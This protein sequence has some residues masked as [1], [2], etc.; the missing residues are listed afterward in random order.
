MVS[1]ESIFER[2]V[3]AEKRIKA[4]EES[5]RKTTG[6]G[7]QLGRLARE[8]EDLKTRLIGSGPNPG[9]MKSIEEM[10]VKIGNLETAVKAAYLQV[11]EHGDVLR[12]HEGRIEGLEY[13]L[14]NAQV[15]TAHELGSNRN[16]RWGEVAL[17]GC[18][19]GLAGWLIFVV[20]LSMRFGWVAAAACFGI[21]FFAAAHILQKDNL[22]LKLEARLKIPKTVP[23]KTPTKVLPD[24]DT[25]VIDADTTPAT[26]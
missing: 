19:G 1:K 6:N 21:A 2:Q 17:W 4:L 14:N 15:E 11:A 5:L 26:G 3:L 12:D 23:P 22:W 24:A 7:R 16:N 20:L 18:V 10:E 25:V 8:V 13:G 9:V